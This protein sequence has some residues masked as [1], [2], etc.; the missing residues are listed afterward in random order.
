MKW[1]ISKFVNEKTLDQEIDYPLY[2]SIPAV[3]YYCVIALMAF[4]G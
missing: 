2:E 3:G 4:I 1:N